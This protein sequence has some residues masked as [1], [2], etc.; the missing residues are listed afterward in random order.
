MTRDLD[1]EL[2]PYLERAAA[3]SGSSFEF[4]PETL[5][6]APPWDYEVLAR[7]LVLGAG[8]IL[9]LGTGCGEVL[10][11]ILAGARARAV[12]TEAWSV[13]AALAARRLGDL[14]RVVRASSLELPFANSS[15]DLVLSRHEEIEP[16]E[17]GRILGPGGAFLT[18]QVVSEY[19]QELRAFFPD[20]VR[21]PDHFSD[22]QSGL[23]G[24]GLSFDEVRRVPQQVRFR[25][26]GPLVYHLALMP[27][28]L[29]SFSIETHRGALLRL[30]EQIRSSEGLVLTGG[31]YLIRAQAGG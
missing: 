23:Q 5:E 3:V 1:S 9:D 15:F 26:L 21:F 12:A 25:E 31:F 19:W 27:W 7:A 17:V 14:S 18:Q 2:A 4:E 6:P 24:A 22:Y 11:R 20:L 10:S 29:P 30:D 16:A 28:F 13:N 8:S